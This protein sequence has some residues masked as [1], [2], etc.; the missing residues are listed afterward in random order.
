MGSFLFISRHR[1]IVL[2]FAQ[3]PTMISDDTKSII[4]AIEINLY[5]RTKT[6]VDIIP[7]S[8]FKSQDDRLIMIGALF[9][10]KKVLKDENDRIWIVRLL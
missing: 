3:I 9:R 2:V 6:F 1:S 5:S 7:M 10:I 8:Y 4:F